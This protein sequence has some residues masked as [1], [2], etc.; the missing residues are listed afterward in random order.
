MFV[1][2]DISVCLLELSDQDLI[3]QTLAGDEQAFSALIERY[4]LPLYNF[5]R[6]CLKEYEWSSDVLQFVLL[7]LYLS[8]PKLQHS[9]YSTRTKSP[10]K[11]WLFQVAWNRCVDERRKQRSL[12]FCEL[13][14]WDEREEFS[15]VNII[16]DDDPLPEVIAEQHE[17]QTVLR[18]AIRHLPPHFR[19]VVLLR[20]TRELS[21]REIGLALQMPENTA[22]TYFQRARPLLQAALL[23]R[24]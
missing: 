3:V 10:L 8:L 24:L 7:Q 11:A 9:L 12:L 17:L 15:L 4:H 14:S 13:D 2:T 19:A 18:Q 16:P 23:Q 5:I 6:R 20:Y 22:K 1:Q 21:F